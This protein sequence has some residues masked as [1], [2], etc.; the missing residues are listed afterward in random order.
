VLATPSSKL[1]SQGN[2]PLT[3]SLLAQL[4]WQKGVTFSTLYA[5]FLSVYG[6][7]DFGCVTVLSPEP[8][9]GFSICGFGEQVNRTEIAQIRE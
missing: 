2:A 3:L 4:E 6:P 9:S 7:G 1:L 8:K 5:E